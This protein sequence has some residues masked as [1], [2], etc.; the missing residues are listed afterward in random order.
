MLQCSSRVLFDLWPWPGDDIVPLMWSVTVGSVG[1]LSLGLSGE[2]ILLSIARL[3]EP[4][5]DT[6]RICFPN[7]LKWD[8]CRTYVEKH[9]YSNWNRAC[10]FLVYCLLQL[11]LFDEILQWSGRGG[12]ALALPIHN[13]GNMIFSRGNNNLQSL[14][15]PNGSLKWMCLHMQKWIS[16][17]VLSNIS[18]HTVYLNKLVAEGKSQ[19]IYTFIKHICH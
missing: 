13:Y 12:T 18:Q 19:S 1:T 3:T 10:I 17:W 7:S 6:K 14:S 4:S 16:L 11:I 2:D 8:P 9:T 5:S 15:I